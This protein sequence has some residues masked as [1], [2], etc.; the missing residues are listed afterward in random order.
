MYL[1]YEL[2]MPLVVD[3]PTYW[4]DVEPLGFF[5]YKEIAMNETEKKVAIL[6]DGGFYR[7]R[8]QTLWG[9]KSAADRATELE[10]YC[11]LHLQEGSRGNKQRNSLYRIFYYDCK[12]SDKKMHHLLTNKAIDL[13]KSDLYAWNTEFFDELMRKRKFAMRLGRLSDLQHYNLKHDSTKALVKGKKTLEDLTEDDFEL[14]VTQ[15]GVDMM[16]GVDIASLSFKQQ[17]EQIILISADSDFVPAA[18]L[19]RREGIDFILD[20]MGIKIQNDLIEHID[21]L[22]TKVKAIKPKVEIILSDESLEDI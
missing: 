5:I 12:P 4:E 22:R 11:R 19:A 7:R 14:V 2:I 20:P 8:A 1:R 18:K 6:V 3:F 15:K 17:V 9:K 21:G 10:N 13:A 16:I